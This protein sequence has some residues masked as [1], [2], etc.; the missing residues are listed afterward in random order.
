M[1][2]SN[3]THEAQYYFYNVC[4]DYDL[5]HDTN[6]YS[7]MPVMVDFEKTETTVKIQDFIDAADARL[8]NDYQ[9]ALFIT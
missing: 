7:I 2:F 5:N 1:V 3:S 4:K 6:Q 8:I 9:M